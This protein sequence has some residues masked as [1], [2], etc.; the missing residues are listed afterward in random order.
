MA[1]TP[2]S[3]K[4]RDTANELDA[5]FTILQRFQNASQPFSDAKRKVFDAMLTLRTIANDLENQLPENQDI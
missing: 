4:L 5:V 1:N 3:I 2:E